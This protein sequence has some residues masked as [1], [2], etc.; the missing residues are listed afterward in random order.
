M[1]KADD[2]RYGWIVMKKAPSKRKRTFAGVRTSEADRPSGERRGRHRDQLGELPEV[3]GGGSEEELVFCAVRASEAQAVQLQD[4]LEVRE[5]HLD[6]LPL[7][8]GSQISICQRQITSE[9][10]RAFMDRARDF[11]RGLAGATSL[12]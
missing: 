3:L 12:L 8:P 11:A 7:A 2:V 10:A 9:I 6:L 4:A 1:R 5:Q